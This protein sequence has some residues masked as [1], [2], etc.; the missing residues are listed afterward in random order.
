MRSVALLSFL[1]MALFLASCDEGRM[2][3]KAEDLK[4]EVAAGA[5]S[6]LNRAEGALDGLSNRNKDEDFVREAVKHNQEEIIMLQEGASRGTDSRLKAAARKMLADHRKLSS[7]MER[8]ASS[9]SISVENANGRHD[10]HGDNAKQGA[11]WDRN[12]ADEMVEHHESDIRRFENAQDDVQDTELKSMISTTLPI[13]RRHL[14]D[15]RKL[16]DQ[17]K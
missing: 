9:K 13:L 15:A 11:D 7:E 16:R 1:F 12:W 8:F 17:L 3:Q 10:T 4:D 5:D 6:A 14:E 2:E